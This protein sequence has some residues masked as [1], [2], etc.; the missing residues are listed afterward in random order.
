MFQAAALVRQAAR[1]GDVDDSAFGTSIDSIFRTDPKSVADAFGGVHG[2]MPGLRALRDHLGRR[3]E[4]SDPEVTGYVIALMLLER[5][6]VQSPSMLDSLRQGIRTLESLHG[7]D[8]LDP[9][10]ISGLAR[11]YTDTISHLNPRILVHGAPEHLNASATADRIR[12]LL[13]AGIRAAVLWRQVGGSRIT[14]LFGRKRAVAAA[15]YALGRGGNG[16]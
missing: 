7:T 5:K 1:H 4:N 3:S 12:A 13:L 11:L 15:E 16:G 10:V 9:R 8:P 2:L 6:L 14:L